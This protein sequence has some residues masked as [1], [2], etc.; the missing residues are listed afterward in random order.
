MTHYDGLENAVTS[1]SLMNQGWCLVPRTTGR[2]RSCNRAINRTT[3][4]MVAILCS[5]FFLPGVIRKDGAVNSRDGFA[6]EILERANVGGEKDCVI[7]V[8]V[9]KRWESL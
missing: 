9:V 4:L 1:S 7:E 3:A 6:K 5:R 2:P 8:A